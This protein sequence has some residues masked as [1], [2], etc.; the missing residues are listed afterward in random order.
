MT[1][2]EYLDKNKITL[3]ELSQRTGVK[4]SALSKLRRGQVGLTKRTKQMFYEKL[5]VEIEESPSREKQL[6]KTAETLLKELY[7]KANEISNLKQLLQQKDDIIYFL[8]RQI[9]QLHKYSSTR[10]NKF[11]LQK[12]YKILLDNYTKLKYNIDIKEE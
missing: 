4:I 8:A 11:N 10:S 6:E 3:T 2:Q 1:I 7:E 12:D 5:K 9:K